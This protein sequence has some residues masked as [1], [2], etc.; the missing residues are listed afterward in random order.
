[1]TI[2]EAVRKARRTT[3]EEGENRGKSFDS[4]GAIRHLEQG[5]L[6]RK[7]RIAL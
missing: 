2:F 3:R 7:G 5:T 4:S 6:V 1:M